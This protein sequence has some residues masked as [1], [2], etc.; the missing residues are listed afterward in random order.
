MS[1]MVYRG[2]HIWVETDVLA[3][4][5]A[6]YCLSWPRYQPHWH[7]R[8]TSMK[9]LIAIV[10]IALLGNAVSSDSQVVYWLAWAVRDKMGNHWILVVLIPTAS[11]SYEDGIETCSSPSRSSKPPD[12]RTLIVSFGWLWAEVYYWV[13]LA[14]R[15]CPMLIDYL[16]QWLY[17][18]F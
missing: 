13:S 1:R 6:Y 11:P 3:N 17:I 15:P 14:Y 16:A 9:A 18:D 5:L 12:P 10:A 7:S 2:H 4:I 8:W